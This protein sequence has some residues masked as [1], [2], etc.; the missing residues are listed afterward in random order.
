MHW[1]RPVIVVLRAERAI[2]LSLR[3]HADDVKKS[4]IA[5]L[6]TEKSKHNR[7]NRLLQIE[8]RELRLID[9]I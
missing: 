9:T 1:Y 6:D 3:L 2:V 8:I 5:N 4:S 7:P